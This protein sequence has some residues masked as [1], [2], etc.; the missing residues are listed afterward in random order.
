MVQLVFQLGEGKEMNIKEILKWMRVDNPF[1]REIGKLRRVANDMID[2]YDYIEF[3]KGI[4]C[5]ASIFANWQ[6]VRRMFDVVWLDIDDHEGRGDL[7]NK[8]ERVLD[9]LH[10]YEPRVY[11]TG[12]GYHV[13]LLIELTRLESYNEVVRKWV[14]DMGLKGYVDRIGN[15]RQLGRIP[16]TVNGYVGREVILIEKGKVSKELG[17]ELKEYDSVTMERSESESERLFENIKDMSSMPRCVQEGVEILARTGE[18]EH[19]YRLHI[20]AFLLRVWDYE[21]VK[22]V[23]RMASDFREDRTDYQ[24]KYILSKNI[25]AF[26][27]KTAMEKGICMEKCPFYPSVNL[28]V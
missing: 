4:D 15:M 26:K 13:Y 21:D 11:F 23:F 20:A 19:D 2:L 10:E 22:D 25:K 14:C 6:V 17:K 24:L 9:L 3:Q 16:G 18:L 7:N 12:R 8:L 28:W 27:C 5:Y 1:P